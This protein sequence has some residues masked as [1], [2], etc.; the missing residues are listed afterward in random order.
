MKLKSDNFYVFHVK[1]SNLSHSFC[2]YELRDKMVKWQWSLF[3]WKSSRCDVVPLW[4]TLNLHCAVRSSVF[5]FLTFFYFLCSFHW[6]DLSLG[7]VYVRL[8][9][10]EKLI[11]TEELHPTVCVYKYPS[12]LNLNNL[13]EF[14]IGQ[15]KGSFTPN[16]YEHKSNF[17]FFSTFHFSLCG[18]KKNHFVWDIDLELVLATLYK[19]QTRK[20]IFFFDL[21]QMSMWN[22]KWKNYWKNLSI[23]DFGAGSLPFNVK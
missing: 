15:T 20:R 5:S 4:E 16:E 17:C 7:Q 14:D 22:N 21:F 3:T 8:V 18:D 19:H 12:R 11:R 2:L 1:T 23:G 10:E 13:I 6:F 9:R